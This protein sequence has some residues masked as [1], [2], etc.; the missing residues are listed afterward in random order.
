MKF[1][2]H[3]PK[4]EEN[5]RK[6]GVSFEEAA[7]VFEAD[8]H[9]LL[10][11]DKEHSIGEERLIC[12]GY[13]RDGNLLTI[14]HVEKAE[15]L[16]RF[17]DEAGEPLHERNVRNAHAEI[18]AAAGLLKKWQLKSSRHS[19]A[20]AMLAS[21]ADLKMI[22]TRLGHAS[23]AITADIYTVVAEEKQ[24]EASERLAEAFGIGKK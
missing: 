18:C 14:S 24:R 6:H 12:I 21:G 17:S 10:L 9:Y 2:W 16:I 3:R 23:I 8:P 13:S 7:T 5:L 4:A 15:D 20:S 1:E 19:M 22:S 11:L